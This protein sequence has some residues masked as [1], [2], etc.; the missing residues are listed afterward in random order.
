MIPSGSM[1]MGMPDVG[2][3]APD[4]CPPHEVRIRRPYWLGKHEVTVKEF[5]NVIQPDDAATATSSE[6]RHPIRN[7]TWYEAE[8]FCRKLSE[9]QVEK[10]AN[11]VYRLPTEAE[12]EYACRAGSEAYHWRRTR[13]NDDDSGEAAGTVPPLPVTP[14]GTYPPNAFGLHD[15]RGNVWEWTADWHDRT[16]YARSPLDDPQGPA[17]GL[18]KV[19]RGGDWI[20]VGELCRINYPIMP[21]WKSSPVVGFRVVCEIV[22]DHH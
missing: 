3:D 18:L 17:T 9:L 12:W 19:V 1:T 20:F 21:P 5:L 22:G 8:Q 16:Y 15:M 6:D 7:V 11:R 2:F 13:S 14:V 4:D 10:Q